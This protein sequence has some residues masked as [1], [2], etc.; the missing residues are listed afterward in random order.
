[1]LSNSQLKSGESHSLNLQDINMIN[2]L[3]EADTYFIA[4]FKCIPIFFEEVRFEIVL[5]WGGYK[6]YKGGF[7]ILTSPTF[8]PPMDISQVKFIIWPSTPHWPW[9]LHLYI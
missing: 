9:R 4:T 3:W 8:P 5:I 2:I 6:T 1:M 7:K